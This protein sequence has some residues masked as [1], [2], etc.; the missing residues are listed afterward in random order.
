M[1]EHNV[2]DIGTNGISIL[3]SVFMILFDKEETKALL[4]RFIYLQETK[5]QRC[6]EAMKIGSTELVEWLR[7]E[8][9]PRAWMDHVIPLD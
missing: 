9:S 5:N 6:L 3:A 4:S 1:Q 7:N 2:D 8:H